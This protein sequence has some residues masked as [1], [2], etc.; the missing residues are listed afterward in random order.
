MQPWSCCV[1][2]NGTKQALSS[3]EPQGV[4]AV[5]NIAQY[6]NLPDHNFVSAPAFSDQLNYYRTL[7]HELGYNAEVRIMRRAMGLAG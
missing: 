4:A 3:H 2:G 1:E 5:F 6:D 7:F